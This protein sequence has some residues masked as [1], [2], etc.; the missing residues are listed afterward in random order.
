MEIIKKIS[1]ELAN[2]TYLLVKNQ[3]VIIVDPAKDFE[4]YEQTIIE[5]NLNVIAVILTHGH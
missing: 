2:N 1:G 4:K 5:Q 3:N